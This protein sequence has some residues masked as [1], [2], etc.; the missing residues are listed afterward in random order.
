MALTLYG[1]TSSN[2]PYV[3]SVFVAL[4]EKNLPF[5]V[6]TVA[7]DQG[8]QRSPAFTS[9]SLASRV[10]TLLDDDFALSESSAI[11]DYLE[12]AYPAPKH[13]ASCRSSPTCAPAPAK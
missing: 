11:V 8:E 13:R 10:P 6:K 9:R 4:R 1:S 5:E 7:L 2:S 12:D 3:L